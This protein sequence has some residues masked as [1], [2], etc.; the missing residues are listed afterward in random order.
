MTTDPDRIADMAQRIARTLVTAHATNLEAM[1]AMAT[2][3]SVRLD[4]A[5]P[6]HRAEACRMFTG[7]VMCAGQL[8]PQDADA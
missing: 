4:G 8:A 7:A 3:L 2:V 5:S 6:E 1:A